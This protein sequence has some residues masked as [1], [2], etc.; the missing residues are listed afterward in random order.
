MSTP[1]KYGAEPTTVDGYRFDS[2]LEA[3]RYQYLRL[4]ERAENIESLAVHPSFELQ[5]GF[6]VDGKTYRAISYEADFSY[7]DAVTNDQVVEDCKGTVT[8]AAKLKLKM[9]AYRYKF[10]VTIVRNGDF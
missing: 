4:L 10:A 6:K 7:V 2:K 3:R 9:F 1:T 8:E 5:P